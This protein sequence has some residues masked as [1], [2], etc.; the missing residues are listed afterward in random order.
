MPPVPTVP[1][2]PYITPANGEIK[3]QMGKRKPILGKIGYNIHHKRNCYLS[4]RKFEGK[5][6]MKTIAT[7]MT[8]L[9]LTGA[10]FAQKPAPKPEPL[11]AKTK[12]L[13][14]NHDFKPTAKSPKST[15]KGKTYY[16]CCAGCKPTFDKEPEKYVKADKPKPKSGGAKR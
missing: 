5:V 15:Y 11:P 2:E 12:C 1:L 8:V 10:A 9:L 16:F 13:V 4:N 3:R 7:C 14:M 6:I